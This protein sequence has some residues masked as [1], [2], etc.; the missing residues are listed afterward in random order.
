[1]KKYSFLVLLKLTILFP[2]FSQNNN[3]TILDSFHDGIAPAILNN[4]LG[5][6]NTKGETIVPLVLS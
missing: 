1:M 3:Y 5:Y 6:I 4:K 2:I